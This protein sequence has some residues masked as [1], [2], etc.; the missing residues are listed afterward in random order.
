MTWVSSSGPPRRRSR[1][2]S[3]AASRKSSRLHLLRP[4]R[5]SPRRSLPLRNPRLR[6]VRLLRCRRPLP[7]LLRPPRPSRRHRRARSPQPSR[8]P[9]R[10]HRPGP[11][12]RRPRA[13]SRRPRRHAR[14]LPY[15]VRVPRRR[16]RPPDRV[17][18]QLP[19]ARVRFPGLVPAFPARVRLPLVLPVPAAPAARVLRAPATTRSLPVRAWASAVR[20]QKVHRR[21]VVRVPGSATRVIAATAAIVSPG[22]VPVATG[23]RV[24]VVA[25]ALRACRDRTPG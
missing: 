22:R 19:R 15:L 20:V 18:V 11:R 4:L 17:P 6:R 1:L 7:H 9:N 25:V 12:G 2:P 21:P 23:C 8:A 13:P 3:N 14:A 24:P 5:H 16:V 10:Q